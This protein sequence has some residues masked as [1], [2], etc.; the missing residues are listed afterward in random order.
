[1]V[2]LV[3]VPERSEC[4]FRKCLSQEINEFKQVSSNFILALEVLLIL[5]LHFNKHQFI[6]NFET[7]NWV[8]WKFATSLRTVNHYYGSY[9]LKNE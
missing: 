9:K 6:C 5:F 7:I 1:V 3:D 2:F 8:S 4:K